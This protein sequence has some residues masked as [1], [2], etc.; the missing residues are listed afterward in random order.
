V[1]YNGVRYGKKTGKYEKQLDDK[2]F[3]ELLK[4]FNENRF[5]RFD[6]DYGMDLVDAPTIT[7]SYSEKGK[8][9]TVKG[10]SK[11]PDKLREIMSLLDKYEDG[12]EGW[13]QMEKVETEVKP[14]TIIDNQIII[15][16]GE[17]MILATWLQEY[18][19][20]GVRLM[21]KIGGSENMWLIRFDKTKIEPQEM[22]KMVKSDKY[23]AEAQ[24]NTTVSDR[25]N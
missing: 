9:K 11:F 7:I 1:K 18:K 25:E 2:T 12:P 3:F 14:E 16:T 6:D 10:K 15:K 4:I 5:W 21:R 8:T 17:G 23:I 24:F 19:E 20:Y 22:L 13:T